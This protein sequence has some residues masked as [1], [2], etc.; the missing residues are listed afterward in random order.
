MLGVAGGEGGR[1]GGREGRVV[2]ESV[3]AAAEA[4]AAEGR[5]WREKFSLSLVGKKG[6]EGRREGGKVEERRATI[7]STSS[8]NGDG[9]ATKKSSSS[10]SRSKA[11][12]SSKSSSSNHPSSKT[13]TKS[14]STSSKAATTTTTTTTT[15]TS[16]SS[17]S[18]N[19]SNN[20]D[21]EDQ[22]PRVLLKHLPGLGKATRGREGGIEVRF[23]E[24]GSLLALSA[25]GS[26]VRYCEGREGGREGGY[27]S[28]LPSQGGEGK[29]EKLPKEMKRKLRI[30]LTQ[31]LA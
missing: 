4:V 14:P 2:Y 27:Y 3:A 5:R 11:S 24:D 19:N 12:S 30:V 9:A 29:K 8:G 21:E 20:K 6:R 17:S 18:N 1:E 28:L 16:S 10:K 31:F 26:N 23:E 7:C 13:S 15:T 22:P 25:D